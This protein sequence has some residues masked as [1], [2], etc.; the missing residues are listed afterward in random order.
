MIKDTAVH[1]IVSHFANAKLC[2]TMLAFKESP[3]VGVLLICGLAIDALSSFFSSMHSTV[4]KARERYTHRPRITRE[5]ID[6]LILSRSMHRVIIHDQLA[7]FRRF[8][9]S[10]RVKSDVK[11]IYQEFLEATFSLGN[12][13][14]WLWCMAAW[15][16]APT[17]KSGNVDC[18]GFSFTTLSC[19]ENNSCQGCKA[20]SAVSSSTRE[21]TFR[22]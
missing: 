7:S 8:G 10:Q 6:R 18:S 1:W 13:F 15:A 2:T 4:H 11:D 20:W 17:R 21:E 22:L 19:P 5:R 12:H 3:N 16:V 9:T 14:Y